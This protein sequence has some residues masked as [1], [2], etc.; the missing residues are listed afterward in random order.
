MELTQVCI[1]LQ[2]AT[3]LAESLHYNIGPLYLQSHPSPAQKLEH[4]FCLGPRREDESA[5]THP[6]PNPS[7]QTLETRS[8]VGIA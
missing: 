1:Q 4:G 8:K 3:H 5:H 2:S 6:V 7:W